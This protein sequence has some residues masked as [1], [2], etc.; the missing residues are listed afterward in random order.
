M[1]SYREATLDDAKALQSFGKDQ[2]RSTFFVPCG[3]SEVDL[4][5]YFDSDYSLEKVTS[6]IKDENTFVFLAIKDELSQSSPGIDP[7]IVGYVS[8]G[9]PCT[10][11]HEDCK[12]RTGEI[13]KLYVSM[14]YR[15]QGVAQKL[16]KEGLGWFDRLD[17]AAK[18]DNDLFLSV[19]S[20][21]HRAQRF[22]SRY[23][24]AKK[25]GSYLYPV[26]EC[27]DEEEI[28]RVKRVCS[29]SDVLTDAEDESDVSGHGLSF[30]HGK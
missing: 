4:Q 28:W 12:E 27:M 22:Y 29:S 14:E 30:Q 13:N 17:I 18:F 9:G 8:V 25:V 15:G 23:L 21:N 19:W 26:G 24:G 1:L 20:G 10:L 2:F 16:M 11:P 3:Y 7:I 6:W 5:C